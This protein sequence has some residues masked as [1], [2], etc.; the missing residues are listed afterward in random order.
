M[1]CYVTFFIYQILR[2]RC[3]QMDLYSLMYISICVGLLRKGISV[4]WY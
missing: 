2:K 4:F 1:S 3:Y